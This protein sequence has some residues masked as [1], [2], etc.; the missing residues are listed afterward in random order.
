VN[1]GRGRNGGKRAKR[2]ES[3]RR[4]ERPDGGE[5][6]RE[7][8]RETRGGGWVGRRPGRKRGGRKGTQDNGAQPQMRGEEGR[9]SAKSKARRGGEERRSKRTQNKGDKAE[10]RGDIGCGERDKAW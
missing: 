8:E 2:A 7:R 5:D 1:D 6:I 3:A 4:A 10:K 9:R